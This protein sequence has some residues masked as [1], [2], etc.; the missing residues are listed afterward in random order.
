MGNFLSKNKKLYYLLF[1]NIIEYVEDIKI[2]I[3]KTRLIK[4]ELQDGNINNIEE[5]KKNLFEIEDKLNRISTIT[6]LVHNKDTE[7]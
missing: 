6:F 2:I 1:K 5:L 3:D 7:K 4:L